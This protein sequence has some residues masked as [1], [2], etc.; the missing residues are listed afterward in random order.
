MIDRWESALNRYIDECRGK[1]FVWGKHDCSLFVANGLKIITGQDY[2]DLFRGL[3]TNRDEA[4]Q[5]LEPF[6]GLLGFLETKFLKINKNMAQRGDIVMVD[7][8][9]CG[10]CLGSCGFFVTEEKGLI[11]VPRRLWATAFKTR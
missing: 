3:Y 4:L 10:L 7:D 5:L 6:G 11:T 9:T 1:P 8:Y 2:A